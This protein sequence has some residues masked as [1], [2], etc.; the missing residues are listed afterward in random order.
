M[1]L[2]PYQ[3]L[4][5]C[6]YWIGELFSSYVTMTLNPYQGLKH[7]GANQN[8]KRLMV[9]MTLNPYQGLKP[10]IAGK[11]TAETSSQ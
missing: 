11:A 6:F 4:K 7:K 10:V 8:I 5:P 3:G 1:T 9:T 2:N